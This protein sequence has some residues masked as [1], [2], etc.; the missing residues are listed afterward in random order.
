MH[1]TVLERLANLHWGV[2]KTQKQEN[3]QLNF[4]RRSGGAIGSVAASHSEIGIPGSTPASNTK[5]RRFCCLGQNVACR[6]GRCHS[7]EHFSS[8]A[9]PCQMGRVA[10]T[11]SETGKSREAPSGD[12]VATWSHGMARARPGNGASPHASIDRAWGH[13]PTWRG[14]PPA[15][16][17]ATCHAL[18]EVMLAASE[19]ATRRRR[20]RQKVIYQ[21]EATGSGGRRRQGDASREKRQT[22]CQHQ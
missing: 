6:R 5:P 7:S 22:Q 4:S 17:K 18:P 1:S 19:G 12:I 8:S 9:R 13:S 2:H 11:T 10:K 16:L 14:C 20:R 21:R 3:Q 15:G